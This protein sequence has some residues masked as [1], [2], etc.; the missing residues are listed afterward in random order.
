MLTR[1]KEIYTIWCVL[2]DEVS[3]FRIKVESDEPVIALK[4]KIKEANPSLAEVGAHHLK[5]FHVEISKFE[6]MENDAKEAAIDRK[7]SE[8][9]MEMGAKK[10]LAD[11]FE[12]V[13]KEE[14]LIIVQYPKTGK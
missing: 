10:I 5:L 11:V 14:T 3:L 6:D 1:Q 12:G 13:V 9:P 4:E 8:H 7:L 2:S